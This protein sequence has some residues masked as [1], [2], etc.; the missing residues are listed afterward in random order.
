RAADVAAKRAADQAKRHAEAREQAVAIWDASTVACA[1]HPYLLRKQVSAHGI[2]QS[3]GRLVVPMRDADGALHSLQ[4][5]GRDGEKRYARDGRVAGCQ[6]IIGEPDRVICVCEGFATA[7]SV[8]QCTGIPVAVAFS[9]GNMEAVVRELRAKFPCALIVVCADDDWQTPGNPGLTEATK[10]ARAVGGILA[11]PEFG[12]E[13][14]DHATDFNDMHRHCGADAVERAV[15]QAIAS[16]VPTY[17]VTAPNAPAADPAANTW[18][19]SLDPAAF[20]GIA[21]EMVR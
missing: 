6:F 20:H 17:R 1:E 7:A 2:R 21:G 9:A 19:Q 13:R 18:S 11:I 8:H 14:P 16:G 10:A 12:V 15:A 3:G 4:F 5:I